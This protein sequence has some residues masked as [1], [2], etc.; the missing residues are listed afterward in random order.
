MSQAVDV[1]EVE[2]KLDVR[3]NGDHQNAEAHMKR[4][5]REINTLHGKIWILT[6]FKYNI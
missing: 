2:T 5:C 6:F 3:L 1:S 4:E